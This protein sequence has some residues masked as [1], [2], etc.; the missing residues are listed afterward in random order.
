MRH[1]GA[2]WLRCQ[3]AQAWTRGRRAEERRTGAQGDS[4]TAEAVPREKSGGGGPWHQGERGEG[5]AVV[6]AQW[7]GWWGP[8]ALGLAQLEQCGFLF[9]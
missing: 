1:K 3:S 9:N 2:A 5:G 4:F 8:A 6:S 7:A